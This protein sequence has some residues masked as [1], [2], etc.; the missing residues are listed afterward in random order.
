L[1]QIQLRPDA[2]L[3]AQL[4]QAAAVA[5]GILYI[6]C[7][8]DALVARAM[9]H[10]TEHLDR[11][12]ELSRQDDTALEIVREKRLLKA[13]GSIRKTLWAGDSLPIEEGKALPTFSELIEQHRPA[14][15][16][17][18]R[19]LGKPRYRTTNCNHRKDR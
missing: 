12:V 10:Y 18:L 1:K 17:F 16:G 3:G 7:G 4:Q 5:R 13:C 15:R 14:P 2:L 9:E 8:R 11:L 6:R 19:P